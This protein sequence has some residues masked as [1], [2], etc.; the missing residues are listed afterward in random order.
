MS[1]AHALRQ[2]GHEIAFYTG[3]AV[4]DSVR[5][6]GF[7]CFPFQAVDDARVDRAVRG[8]TSRSW[9]PGRWRELMLGTVPEQLRDL[10][11]VWKSWKPDVVVCDIAMWGPILVMHELKGVPVALLSHVASCILPGAQNPLPGMNWLL[12][13]TPVRPLAPAIAWIMRAASAGVPRGAS[14]LRQA[15]GLPPL[16]GTVT[17]FTGTLPLYLIPGTPEFDGKRSDLPP[18]VHYV[19][20]CLWDKGGDQPAPEWIAKA[21]RDR[22]CVVVAEGT[23]YPEKPRLLRM[24]ARGLANLPLNAFLV[25][26]QGR[27][28]ESLNLGPLAPNVRLENWTPLSDVLP[29]A[30]VLVAGGDSE[31]V[32]AALERMVPMVLV[33][34]I[35]DQPQLSWLVSTAGAGLRVPGWRCSPKGLRTAVAKV[36]AEQQFRENAARIREGF[37]GY[38]GAD[39]AARSLEKLA[40]ADSR[41]RY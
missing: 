41:Q 3:A 31:T 21:P 22:P 40:I 24:A 30:D 12:H 25:A 23:I 10:E 26:G 16:A 36:L 37:R 7:P 27:S 2:R 20:P 18:S 28:L 33:P 19:G 32:M 5:K 13:G 9:R 8:L 35:L 17:E 6:Q 29:I 1:V 39:L 15:W 38:S 11:D 14:T 4:L 34:M